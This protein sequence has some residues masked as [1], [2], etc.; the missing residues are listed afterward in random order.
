MHGNW[1][2][3]NLASSLNIGGWELKVQRENSKLV[4]FFSVYWDSCLHIDHQS[5]NVERT[6][7][8][9]QGKQWNLEAIGGDTKRS[10]DMEAI[11][12]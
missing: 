6:E 7:S 10:V 8:V 11:Q 12:D 4:D 9:E 1:T 2:S 5:E 3:K